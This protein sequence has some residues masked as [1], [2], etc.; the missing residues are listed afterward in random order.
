MD[1]SAVTDNQSTSEKPGDPAASLFERTIVSI[2]VLLASAVR[3]AFLM[4]FRP[5]RFARFVEESS[6]TLAPPYSFLITSLLAA[7]ICLRTAIAFYARHADYTLLRRL[8]ESTGS[9]TLEGVFVLT[10]PCI[11]LVVMAGS[12]V[13]RWVTPKVPIQRNAVVRA[14]CYASGLQFTLVATG[15]LVILILKVAFGTATV[16]SDRLFNQAAFLGI[17]LLLFISSIPLFHVIRRVGATMWARSR[18]ASM[19]LSMLCTTTILTGVSIVNSVSFDLESTITEVR[20]RH[21]QETLQ[22]LKI[23]V[24]TFDS[25]MVQDEL[26]QPA[27]EMTLGFVNVSD[28]TLLVP[29][30]FELEHAYDPRLTKLKVFASSTDLAKEPGWIIQPGETKL[31]RWMLDVPPWCLE[32]AHQQTTLPVLFSC[33]PLHGTNDVFNTHPI[34]DSVT[35]LGELSWPIFEARRNGDREAVERITEIM[36]GTIVR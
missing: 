12:G 5:Y 25:R 3:T 14:V 32:E 6:P 13:A 22:D 19:C 7:G 18:V 24:R 35:V 15:C 16:V 2:I 33:F 4:M 34:G 30:P 28:A 36:T 9:L 11:L 27:M 23:A 8:S 31:A 10:I 20:S 1:V 29:R 17:V 26:G 21:Q